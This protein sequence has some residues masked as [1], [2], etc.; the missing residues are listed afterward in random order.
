MEDRIS[1]IE[2]MI[3]EIY[4]SVKETVK[5]KTFLTQ[6][7]YEIWD[8]MKRSNSRITGGEEG[9]ESQLKG[10]Q[11]IFNQIIGENLPN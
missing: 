8:P 6:N 1:S 7:I 3:E 5:S 4:I 2:D 9:E 11:H 10:P